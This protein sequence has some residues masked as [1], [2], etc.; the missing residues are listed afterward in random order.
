[1]TSVLHTLFCALIAMA[2]TSSHTVLYPVIDLA[3]PF[4]F[5]LSCDRIHITAL[6]TCF[7]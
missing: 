5:P 1:M 4:S 3:S 7:N 2:N 6:L